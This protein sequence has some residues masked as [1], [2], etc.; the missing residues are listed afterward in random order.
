LEQQE[1]LLL[2]LGLAVLGYHLGVLLLSIPIPFASVKRWGPILMRDSLYASILVFS[3]NMIL[4]TIPY[5]QS[6]FGLSWKSF[7]IWILGRT[8]WLIGWK[9]AIST[10][11][12]AFSQVGGG[13][14]LHTLVD[15][16]LKMINYALTTLYSI[17]S[18]SIILRS[19][20]AK[21]IIIGI[22]LM[23]VPFRLTRSVG[24]SFIAFTIVFMIGL[25]FLPSFISSF[26]STQLSGPPSNANVVFGDISVRTI[27][28]EPLCYPVIIGDVGEESI[29]FL[30]RGDKEGVIHS[31]FPDGG[32]PKNASYHVILDYMGL[33]T[34]LEPY[35][36]VP[37]RDYIVVS[38]SSSG[39]TVRLNLTS[40]LIIDQPSCY[41][42]VYRSPEVNIDS[43]RVSGRRGI[44]YA[45]GPPS[46]YIEFR[47][48]SPNAIHFSVLQ[49]NTSMSNGTWSWYG[50][51]GYFYRVYLDS[52]VENVI[53]YTAEDTV[54]NPPLPSV[55]EK[56]YLDSIG[57]SPWTD[58]SRMAA[59]VLMSW[60]VLPAVYLFI[61]GSISAALAYLIGGSRNKLPLR[62][63]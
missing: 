58:F 52:S 12:T 34:P 62:L 2:A 48:L 17:F 21:F 61:L 4:G 37:D 24:S 32:L 45:S 44:I 8:S 50:L 10:L 55:K 14:F 11:L 38:D 22:L 25:P 59:T 7:D 33:K 63:W 15:P 23:S 3:S 47:T 30:Y 60:I 42:I 49:G 1:L 39:Y 29:V 16:F 28:G 31:V 5:F 53:V 18:L 36:V 26:S 13:L 43:L 6:L 56:S 40:Y 27:D 46:A 41:T 19:F 54:K 20:Y 35:P 51:K 9:T 57:F